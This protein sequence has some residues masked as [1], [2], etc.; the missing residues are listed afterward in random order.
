MDSFG[1]LL[2]GL[3]EMI[4]GERTVDAI[5][6]GAALMGDGREE[7]RS[8]TETYDRVLAGRRRELDIN[9]L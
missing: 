6:E 8:M 9:D 7:P 2:G 4:G 1:D 5:A 3:F